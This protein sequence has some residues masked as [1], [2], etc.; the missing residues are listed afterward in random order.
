[1]PLPARPDLRIESEETV[2]AGRFPL[3]R[4]RF[5][6]RRFDGAW[7][8]TRTWELWRRGRAG[9]VL[10]YDPVQDRVVLL[11]QY[12]LPAA[13]AG[14]DPVLVEI[15]AGLCDPG[16]DP[17]A[18]LRREAAEEAGM[19]VLRLHRIGDYLLT[20]GGADEYVG[21]YA[22]E[23]RLPAAGVAAQGGL[24]AEHEDIRVR[25]WP[26]EEAIEAALAG[27]MPNVVTAVA[28]LWLA[29][30]RATLRELWAAA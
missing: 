27:A 14:I 10:P 16:E 7:S 12:R 18:T 6:H 15:P 11:E 8:G 22:G 28:L 30:R 17:V 3:D 19:T 29:A 23:V 26:A 20:P 21:L 9:A 2:W 13:A 1:M 25:I 4:V 5:R 24:A